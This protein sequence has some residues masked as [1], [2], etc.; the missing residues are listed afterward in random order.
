MTRVIAVFT[1]VTATLNVSDISLSNYCIA[2]SLQVNKNC[3][4][5]WHSLTVRRIPTHVAVTSCSCYCQRYQY[6]TNVTTYATKNIHN[7]FISTKILK[8]KQVESNSS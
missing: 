6:T 7:D 8:I 2:N 4:I 1:C 5:P 3:D